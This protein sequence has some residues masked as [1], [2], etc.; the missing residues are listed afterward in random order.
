MNILGK[1]SHAMIYWHFK[2]ISIPFLK[3]NYKKLQNVQ[4]VTTLFLFLFLPSYF[5]VNKCII[6]TKCRSY[7][8][9]ITFFFF[10][11]F[12]KKHFFPL[13]QIS[14]VVFS[15]LFSCRCIGFNRRLLFFWYKMQG[16]C[17]LIWINE[18]LLSHPLYYHFLIYSL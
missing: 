12:F 4:S 18:R 7:L 9:C 1:N 8:S 2:K 6:I 17:T 13:R 14:F 5:T 3:N 16:F 15:V 11:K 10:T